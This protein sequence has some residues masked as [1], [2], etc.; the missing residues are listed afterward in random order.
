MLPAIPEYQITNIH[1]PARDHERITH[2]FVPHFSRWLTIDE[3]IGLLRANTCKLYVLA[4]RGEKAFVGIFQATGRR[5]CLRTYADGIWTDNLLSL[6]G[7]RA[8]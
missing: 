1:P 6:P 8:A 7:V 4:Q 3:A 2:V 5:P